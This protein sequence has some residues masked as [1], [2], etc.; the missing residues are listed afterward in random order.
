MG[1]I[2]LFYTLSM[3]HEDVYWDRLAHEGY[4]MYWT[5]VFFLSKLEDGN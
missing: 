2:V 1:Y 4:V 3:L 5:R